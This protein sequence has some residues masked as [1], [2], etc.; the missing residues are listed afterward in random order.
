MNNGLGY[1]ESPS[2]R[3][4]LLEVVPTGPG[5]AG[6]SY[7]NPALVEWEAEQERLLTELGPVAFRKRKLTGDDGGCAHKAI[8]RHFRGLPY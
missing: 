8:W 4:R 2:E 6:H 5:W 1:N 7:K 3:R